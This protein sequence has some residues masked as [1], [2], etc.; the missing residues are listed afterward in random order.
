MYRGGYSHHSSHIRVLPD[1]RLLWK[2]VPIST[3]QMGTLALCTSLL[4]MWFAHT[5]VFEY[6]IYT[7]S[8]RHKNIRNVQQSI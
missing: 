1:A 8:Q 2:V 7:R 3:S 5:K 4:E 6:L